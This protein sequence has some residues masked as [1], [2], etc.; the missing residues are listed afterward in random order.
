MMSGRDVGGDVPS[1]MTAICAPPPFSRYQ[2]FGLAPVRQW[3]IS[4]NRSKSR[5]AN[6]AFGDGL[7]KMESTHTVTDCS[8]P[9]IGL[10]MFPKPAGGAHGYTK[11]VVPDR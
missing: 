5:A 1:E 3:S 4:V 6:T 7:R 10:R 9:A 8:L 11:Q 2:R